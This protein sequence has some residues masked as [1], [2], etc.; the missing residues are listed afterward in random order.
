MFSCFLFR[1]GYPLFLSSRSFM[2]SSVSFSLLWFLSTVFLISVIVFIGSHWF[3]FIFYSSSLK[4]SLFSCIIFSTSGS[5]LITNTLKYIYESFI[6]VSLVIFLLF[7]CCYCCF[8]WNKF[9][10][11]LILLNS[12]WLC[13]IM[14][15]KY[16]SKPWKCVYTKTRMCWFT[17]CVCPGSLVG[18]LDMKWVQLMS[19]PNVCQQLSSWSEVGLEMKGLE[20][21]PGASRGFT[22]MQCPTTPY[23][24]R[25]GFQ[26]SEGQIWAEF[27]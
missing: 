9:L 2:C 10:C 18:E 13:G 21:G 7:C 26:S 27:L 14:W 24:G 16:P 20:A 22:Y 19:F 1:L 23:G 15:N 5:I 25:I 4:S 12:L 11:F 3:F 17:V 8:I 6:S